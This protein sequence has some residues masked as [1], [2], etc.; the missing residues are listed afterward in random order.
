MKKIAVVGVQ[1]SIG[2][3]ILSYLAEEG[4]KPEQVVALEPKS[5]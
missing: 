3:E 2:R 5:A 1:E 4:Y